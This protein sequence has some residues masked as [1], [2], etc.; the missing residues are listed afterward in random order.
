MSYCKTCGN[1]SLKNNTW[2]DTCHSPRTID[3]KGDCVYWEPK[4]LWGELCATAAKEE[5]QLPY[6]GKHIKYSKK[7]KS[8]TLI[9]KEK[10]GFAN[11]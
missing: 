1:C 7:N 10:F 11:G 8:K 4:T 5:P 3:K 2:A 9:I 6:I